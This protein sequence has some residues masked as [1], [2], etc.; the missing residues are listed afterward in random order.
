MRK[1]FFGFL[2]VMLLFAAATVE[3]SDVNVNL[4]IINKTGHTI[5]S[6]NV[7]PPAANN[8]GSDHL[9]DK[10]LLDGEQLVVSIPNGTRWDIRLVDEDGDTYTKTNWGSTTGSGPFSATFTVD[11]VDP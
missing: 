1:Y 6:A 2:V 11:D 7:S 4:T 3:A 8:W 5:H 9:G 10:V